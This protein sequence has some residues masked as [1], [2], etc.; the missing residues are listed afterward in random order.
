MND[1]KLGQTLIVLRKLSLRWLLII[2]MGRYIDNLFGNI[3]PG[4]IIFWTF[5]ATYIWVFIN[6]NK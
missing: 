4:K 5:I 3:I 1:Y 6:S 2:F